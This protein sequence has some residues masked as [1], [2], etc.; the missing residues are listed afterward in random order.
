[1]RPTGKRAKIKTIMKEEKLMAWYWW[2]LI[3]VGVV[4]VGYIKLKVFAKLTSRKKENDESEE[5]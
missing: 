4:A 2:V 3:A 1:M 5:D